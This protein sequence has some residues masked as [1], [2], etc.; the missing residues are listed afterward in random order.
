MRATIF[1]GN[2]PKFF[3]AYRFCAHMLISGTGVAANF[4]VLHSIAG[5]SRGAVYALHQM[6]F[7]GHFG[8]FLALRC[9]VTQGLSG[10]FRL[11]K[12]IN[13]GILI[14]RQFSGYFFRFGGFWFVAFNRTTRRVVCHYRRPFASYSKL[15]IKPFHH[16][17][18]S[19]DL[20]L[21]HNAR[22]SSGSSEPS[23]SYSRK[24]GPSPALPQVSIFLKV[25]EP[26]RP[27]QR[28]KWPVIFCGA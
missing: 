24:L 15:P 3:R 22:N 17:S 13:F 1:R 26:L 18:L 25:N 21:M 19:V 10:S 20:L 9:F 11:V 28:T 23:V 7:V 16:F 5:A 12:R 27:W 14:K 4:A 2:G 8:S 6:N